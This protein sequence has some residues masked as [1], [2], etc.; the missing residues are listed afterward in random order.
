LL[1][2]LFGFCG[3]GTC[4]GTS[5]TPF[6]LLSRLENI[7]LADNI[8]AVEDVQPIQAA[9]TP[10]PAKVSWLKKVGAAIGRILHIVATEAKPIIHSHVS[11]STPVNQSFGVVPSLFLRAIARRVAGPFL[12]ARSAPEKFI[13][14]L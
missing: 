12:I 7:T 10:A 14:R 11:S 2:L 13:C 4:G 1:L 3:S 9:G 8:V 6:D 5:H